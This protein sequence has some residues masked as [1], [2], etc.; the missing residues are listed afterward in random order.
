MSSLV[1]LAGSVFEISCGKQTHRQTE[2]KC[3]P[4]RLPSTWI[5]IM[6]VKFIHHHHHHLSFIKKLTNA[7]II[8]IRKK[9]KIEICKTNKNKN[10]LVKLFWFGIVSLD[11]FVGCSYDIVIVMVIIHDINI[12]DVFCTNY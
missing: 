4:S 6:Q 1:I 5:I 12:T 9:M 2:V 10:A 3:L 7:I 8:Q 11:V